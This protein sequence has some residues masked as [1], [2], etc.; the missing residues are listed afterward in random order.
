[1]KKIII[2]IRSAGVLVLLI[3]ALTVVFFSLNAIVKK[4]VETL[5][6]EMTNVPV[7]LGS[8]RD[9]ADR[10]QRGIGGALCGKSG[11]AVKTASA[12]QIG[13]IKLGVKLGSILSDTIV[14]NE[15]NIQG[16]E[17][18]LEGGLTQNNLT[19]IMD[20]LDSASAGGKKP[21]AE[22]PG[23]KSE[24]KFIVKELVVN[25]AK[26]N[27]SM[28]LLGG[29]S[30]TLPVPPLNLKDIGVAENGVTSA[31][32]V[33]AIMKPLLANITQAATQGITDM[34]GQLQNLGKGGA[35]QLDNATKGLKDL[36][37][38]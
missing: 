8:A 23:Q 17:I 29:K 22:T 26:V 37:K 12:F 9:F 14:I 4:G 24:K 33:Q 18:T 2:G 38:K 36:F 11:G 6:P 35:K 10:R 15:L 31:Q 25:G 32:L 13:D 20:N 34:G 19:K 21:A 30:L 7:R 16:A 5:G 27:L 28:S 1:M 3:V